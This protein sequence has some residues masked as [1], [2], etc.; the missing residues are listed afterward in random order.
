VYS[1][2]L[3]P[4]A[5]RIMPTE[6]IENLDDPRVAP[7]RNVR[8]A[9]LRGGQALFLAEGRLVVESL[10]RSRHHGTRSILVSQKQHDSL[11]AVLDAHRQIPA[12][13]MPQEI[14]NTLV[15]F[16]IHRGVLAAGI[17]AKSTD[18]S[19]LLGV[20]AHKAEESSRVFLLDALANHDNVGGIFR[21]AMAFGVR[22]VLLDPKCCDPLY[23]KSIRVS[24]GAVLHVPFHHQH[25]T[26]ESIALLRKHGYHIVAL[27]P[28]ADAVALGSFVTAARD[29]P[30]LAFCIGA[31]GPGL[32]QSILDAVDSLV[33]IEMASQIDSLN[34]M[35]ASAIVAHATMPATLS[36]TPTT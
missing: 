23:R 17:R 10:L 21:N 1:S 15:G 9:D 8:D 3:T 33:R 30:R 20:I 13:V 12:Y 7:Y 22:G 32:P 4:V 24:M 2:Y 14:M 19:E 26:L 16:D 6:F 35:V 25:T 29:M 34:A 18:P 11:R 31:E 5:L 27:T 36:T 28:R